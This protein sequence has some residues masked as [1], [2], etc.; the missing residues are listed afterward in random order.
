VSPPTPGRRRVGDTRLPRAV[1]LSF[2]LGAGLLL[3]GA[4]LLLLRLLGVERIGS[5]AWVL[6]VLGAAVG[7]GLV[8]RAVVPRLPVRDSGPG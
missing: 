1:L 5:L 8:V 3:A 6:V 2:A 7:G 4:A